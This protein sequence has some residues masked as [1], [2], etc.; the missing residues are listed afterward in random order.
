[1]LPATS[2]CGCVAQAAPDRYDA[3]PHFE[4]RVPQES[5]RAQ[6]VQAAALV[7]QMAVMTVLGGI[8]GRQLDGWF[9][10]GTLSTMLGILA[11]FTIGMVTLFRFLL[12]RTDDDDD[13]TAAP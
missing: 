2:S 13:D 10:T 5:L 7:T 11:G 8:L 9:A 1:M 4:E 6:G 12:R 3:R